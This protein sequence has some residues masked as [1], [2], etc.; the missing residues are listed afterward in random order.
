[1]IHYFRIDGY[2]QQM[3]ALHNEEETQILQYKKKLQEYEIGRDILKTIVGPELF[4]V[5]DNLIEVIEIIFYVRKYS[6]R[7]SNTEVRHKTT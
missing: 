5:F 1:M 4:T 3:E 7:Q 6:C 2:K